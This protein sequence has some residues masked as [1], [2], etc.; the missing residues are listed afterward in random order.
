MR[1]L[2]TLLEILSELEIAVLRIGLLVLLVIA[3]GQLIRHHLR[4]S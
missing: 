4:G 1:E 3:L 2:H